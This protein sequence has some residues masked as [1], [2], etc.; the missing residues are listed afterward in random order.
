MSPM[1]Y[2]EANKIRRDELYREA[3]KERLIKIA[4][5]GQP[6]FSEKIQFKISELLSKPKGG[7]TKM[8]PRAY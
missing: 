2:Y 8:Q 1:I 4:Q 6:S 3:E 7:T 5:A